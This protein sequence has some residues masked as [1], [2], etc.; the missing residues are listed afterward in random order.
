MSVESQFKQIPT[1]G[2][3]QSVNAD[4]FFIYLQALI[5]LQYLCDRITFFALNLNSIRFSRVGVLFTNKERKRVGS[6]C[7]TLLPHMPTLSMSYNMYGMPD[8]ERQHSW[9]CFHNFQRLIFNKLDHREP[10]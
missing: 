2:T 3:G 10:G 5:V 1:K 8:T 4:F 9:P 7:N 6:W